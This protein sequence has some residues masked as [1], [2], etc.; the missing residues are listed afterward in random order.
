VLFSPNNL[1]QQQ[2][3]LCVP[4]D[5]DITSQS[6]DERGRRN[7]FP[8]RG[9]LSLPTQEAAADQKEE[10]AVPWRRSEEDERGRWACQPAPAEAV[11]LGPEVSL[12][13]N[14]N[15]EASGEGRGEANFRRLEAEDR[16]DRHSS[17]GEDVFSA[18]M[19]YFL[20]I[21]SNKEFFCRPNIVPIIS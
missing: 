17:A 10:E 14:Q 6:E 18:G 3:K 16:R 21:F 4:P 11:K 8:R 9:L 19:D 20:G 13:R 5:T 2:Q 1:Q 15:P 7:I 12:R